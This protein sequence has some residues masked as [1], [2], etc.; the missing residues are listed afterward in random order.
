MTNEIQNPFNK[1]LT[2]AE[3]AEMLGLSQWTIRRF[4]L[5][6]GLPVVKLAGRFFYRMESVERWLADNETAGATDDE[7]CETGTIRAIHA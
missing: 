2:E 3:L 4:R 7:P 6:E 5:N 1:L